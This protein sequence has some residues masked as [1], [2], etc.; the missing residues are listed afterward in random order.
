MDAEYRRVQFSLNNMDGRS[1]VAIRNAID[2]NRKKTIAA[3]E[4]LDKLLSFMTNSTKQ[5]EAEELKIANVFNS[6]RR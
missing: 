5:I 6:S 4:T 3:A 1:A 2:E